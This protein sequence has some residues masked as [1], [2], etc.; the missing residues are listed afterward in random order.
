MTEGEASSAASPKTAEVF[1]H[2]LA[3]CF[4][5]SEPK[6]LWSTENTNT[7]NPPLI[8]VSVCCCFCVCVCVCVYV[9]VCV[10]VCLQ[11][12]AGKQWPELTSESADCSAGFEAH[13][14]TFSVESYFELIHRWK[15]KQLQG[16]EFSHWVNP[17]VWSLASNQSIHT[18]TVWVHELKNP[19][20]SK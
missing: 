5:Q 14:W 19:E 17:S 2:F 1:R 4:C 18:Q 7:T 16:F 9:Y 6:Q 12:S 13:F 20:V 11:L 15:Q 3:F 8:S 10:C